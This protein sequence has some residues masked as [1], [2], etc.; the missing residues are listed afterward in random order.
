MRQQIELLIRD[1]KSLDDNLVHLNSNK[2]SLDADLDNLQKKHEFTSGDMN[3]T[4][5]RLE[6]DNYSLLKAKE[7]LETKL[8]SKNAEIRNVQ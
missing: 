1:N 3:A 5:T 2:K 4:V 6:N 8:T 7:D